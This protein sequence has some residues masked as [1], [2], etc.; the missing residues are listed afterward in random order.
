MKKH[1]N[2]LLEILQKF[3]D[4]I[5]SYFVNRNYCY[6]SRLNT[7]NTEMEFSIIINNEEK[8]TD[9]IKSNSIHQIKEKIKQFNTFTDL[10]KNIFNSLKN[11]PHLIDLK[12]IQSD[13]FMINYKI[14]YGGVFKDAKNNALFSI[15]Y[16]IFQFYKR[17][18][19]KFF[20]E[21]NDE[22]Y[23]DYLNSLKNYIEICNDYKK[24]FGIIENFK[25]FDEQD[26]IAIKSKEFE[27]DNNNTEAISKF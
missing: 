24:N 17:F 23:F 26:L 12:E 22:N 18:K 1:S 4:S 3:Y 15:S 5:I 2:I 20:I 7:E 10:I 25:F 19:E 13:S 9:N 14:D 6:E 27:K 16:S 11:L 21:E 8:K